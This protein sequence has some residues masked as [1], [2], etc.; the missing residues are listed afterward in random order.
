MDCAVETESESETVALKERKI[1]ELKWETVGT[2]V[3]GYLMRVDK[4]KYRDGVSNRYLVRRTDNSI[5]VFSGSKMIDLA[6]MRDD[7]GKFIQI[8]YKG[9]DTS[10]EVS[11]GMNRPKLFSV[12]V[13]DE[14]T[15][16]PIGDRGNDPEI[17]DDDIPF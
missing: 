9:E 4:V 7:V 1:E 2:A 15:L 13:D 16:E 14:R 8:V 12:A 3:G 10:R 5:A 11:V 6:L 17:T